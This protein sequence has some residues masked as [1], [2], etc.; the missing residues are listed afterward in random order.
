MSNVVK[1]ALIAAI[2]GI[3][4]VAIPIIATLLSPKPPINSTQT[5]AGRIVD[6]ATNLGVRGATITMT[7]EPGSYTSED[8]GSFFIT[9]PLSKNMSHVQLHIEKEKYAALDETLNMPSTDNIVELRAVKASELKTGDTPQQSSNFAGRWGGEVSAIGKAFGGGNWCEYE[10]TIGNGSLSIKIKPDATLQAAQLTYMYSDKG[11]TCTGGISSNEHKF[12][13]GASNITG[14]RMH[15]DFV[16]DASNVPKTQAEFDG[17]LDTVGGDVQVRGLLR[18][19]RMDQID[20]F[21]WK[22]EQ[23]AILHHQKL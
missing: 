22:V 12:K 5:I 21:N 17:V 7:G 2:G 16:G 20:P 1:A 8:T 4:G 23:Q 18:I 10:L 13:V 14:N 15:I 11:M 6:K 19:N 9:L 3:I